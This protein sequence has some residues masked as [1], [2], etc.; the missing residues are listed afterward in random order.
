[1]ETYD[2][3]RVM[4]QLPGTQYRPPPSWFEGMMHGTTPPLRVAPGPGSFARARVPDD[5]GSEEHSLNALAENPLAAEVP[6]LF[7]ESTPDLAVGLG[8][9]KHVLADVL[10]LGLEDLGD[11]AGPA[12]AAHFG[13]PEEGAADTMA[14]HPWYGPVAMT[15]EMFNQAMAEAAGQ[16][17]EPQPM[18]N[19]PEP[20]EAAPAVLAE[21]GLESIVGQDPISA[22]AVPGAACGPMMS[23]LYAPQQQMYDDQMQQL[24]DPWMMPCP[25]GPVDPGFGPM[26]GP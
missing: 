8:I 20:F 24:M 22:Q 19:Q 10:M 13:H 4:Y 2:G 6:A 18:A 3:S 11:F 26:P 14:E 17:T 7:Q 1:M 5:L 12:D 15:Q 21:Q 9:P 25:F 16:G 23:D